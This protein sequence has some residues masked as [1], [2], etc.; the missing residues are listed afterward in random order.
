MSR[1]IRKIYIDVA[2]KCVNVMVKHFPKY[3]T[4]TYKQNKARH[5]IFHWL[6]TPWLAS[7]NSYLQTAECL[8]RRCFINAQ[9]T[10]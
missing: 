3:E 2:W 5:R 4:I 10:P 7:E 6:Q 1:K 9:N 8:K